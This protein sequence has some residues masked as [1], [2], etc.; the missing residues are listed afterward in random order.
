[1]ETTDYLGLKLPSRDEDDIADINVISDDFKKV[2]N[3]VQ[4]NEIAISENEEAIGERMTIAE[5]EYTYEK[6][7]NKSTSMD[8]QSNVDYPTTKAVGDFV[9]KKTSVL[10]NALYNSKKGAIISLNDI[11]PMSTDVDIQ[12]ENSV[13]PTM[14]FSDVNVKIGGKNLFVDFISD[15]TTAN[16]SKVT[17]NGDGSVTIVGVAN[18]TISQQYALGRI[19]KGTYTISN[20]L[21]T[22]TLPR[23]ACVFRKLGTNE[24][25]KEISTGN[26]SSQT[27]EVNEDCNATL[28]L[29]G[30]KI[31]EGSF[32]VYPQ[33]EYSSV[34]TEYEQYIDIV[35][36]HPESDGK[37]SITTNFPNSTIFTD[38]DNVVVNAKYQRD[39]NKA[40]EEL[41]NA[42]ISL[43]GNI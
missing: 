41:Q 20:G 1:M 35:E 34:A 33:L 10:S 38:T 23:L 42:I 17:V 18:D 39:I 13:T 19:P 3:K 21:T 12:L 32:T 27:T 26:E 9:K 43:G 2:E 4:K 15:Q 31:A 37:I 29:Y 11:S 28:L 24:Y 14:D 36:V 7:A 40:F 22:G 5:A 8:V 30:S 6:K 16:G 25:I